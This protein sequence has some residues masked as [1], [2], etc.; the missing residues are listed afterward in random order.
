MEPRRRRIPAERQRVIASIVQQTGSVRGSE[1]V[2]ILGVTDET[3]RR[4]LLQLAL[5]GAVR[6]ARG[7][8]VAI[9]PLDEFEHRP[10]PP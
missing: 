5:S 1:L 2:D 10:P 6:R 8:A 7:G 4:D 9:S 3:I